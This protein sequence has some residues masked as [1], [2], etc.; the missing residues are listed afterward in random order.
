MEESIRESNLRYEQKQRENEEWYAAELAK[1]EDRDPE[2]A[3]RQLQI[4]RGWVTVAPEEPEIEPD[5][6]ESVFDAARALST[7]KRDGGSG[8]G[9]KTKADV[10][11]VSASGPTPRVEVVVEPFVDPEIQVHDLKTAIVCPFPMG[12][13]GWRA[14][15]GML[16][17]SKGTLNQLALDGKIGRRK[18]EDGGNVWL[19]DTV[20]LER[21]GEERLAKRCK[22]AAPGKRLDWWGSRRVKAEL[23]EF[24]GWLTAQEAG[25]ILGVSATR[26]GRMCDKGMMP[27]YQE[28][29]GMQGSKLMVP[30]FQVLRIAE[31]PERKERHTKWEESRKRSAAWVEHEDWG[32]EEHD[33]RGESRATR[34]SHGEYLSTKQAALMLG[35]GRQAVDNLR[36][37]GG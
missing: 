13:V 31:R 7:G 21:V 20:E 30:Y 15:A 12:W 18:S 10:R 34:K 23:H 32:I 2:E 11:P 27:C 25:R 28:K 8:K 17:V 16:Q 4:E 6:F 22:V 24:D 3:V 29:P 35:V 19:Y 5:S 36:L 33:P 1:L 14:A 37:R 26:V 9:R